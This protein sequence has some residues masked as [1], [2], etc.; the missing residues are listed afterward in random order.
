[1]TTDFELFKN[2]E[3]LGDKL[4]DLV[5]ADILLSRGMSRNEVNRELPKYT[6]TKSLCSMFKKLGISES[7]HD[8][9]NDPRKRKA[10]AVEEYLFTQFLNNGYQSVKEAIKVVITEQ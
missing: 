3:F 2:R 1:M 6:S 9:T 8:K 5:V 7:P 4:L 10:N